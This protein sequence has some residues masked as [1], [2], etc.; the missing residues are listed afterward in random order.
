MQKEE[1]P[2]Q[3]AVENN[4]PKLREKR[5]SSFS[6]WKREKLHIL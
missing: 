2:P 5:N 4:A 3:K 6:T 1:K